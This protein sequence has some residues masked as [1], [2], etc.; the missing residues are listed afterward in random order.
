MGDGLP[1]T[2]QASGYTPVHSKRPSLLVF[3]W[4]LAVLLPT[5]TT[6]TG[7]VPMPPVE[8]TDRGYDQY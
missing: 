8:T 3:P 7:R 5:A 4:Q 2:V 1:S 6:Q